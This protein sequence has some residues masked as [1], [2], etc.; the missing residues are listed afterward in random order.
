MMNNTV[1]AAI[2]RV[3]TFETVKVEG[4]PVGVRTGSRF[5]MTVRRFG[6]E[7]PFHVFE[8]MDTVHDAEL[9]LAAY[10]EH[11][12]LDLRSLIYDLS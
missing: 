5:L 6:E 4:R 7:N 3:K 8:T 11:E 2:N 9:A 10:V 1:I 12:G